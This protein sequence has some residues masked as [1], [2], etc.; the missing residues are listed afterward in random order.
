MNK[1]ADSKGVY[2]QSSDIRSRTYL[3]YRSDMKR[4]AIV[5]LEIMDWFER[6]LRELHKTDNV[7]VEKSGGDAHMW[8]TRSGKISGEPDYVACINNEEHR[9]EFQYAN[10]GNLPSYD[11]KVSKVGKKVRGKRVPHSDRKFLYILMPSNQFAVFS[12]EWVMQNGKEEG[13]PAWGNR[14]AF[15]VPRDKFSEIFRSGRALAGEIEVTNKKIKLLETQSE[16]IENESKRLSGELQCVVDHERTFRIVPKTL[17]GFY[18]ACF[19]MD[20][21]SRRPENHSLWLVYGSSFYSDEL[22]SRELA[23]LIYSLDFLYG[24]SESL[25]KNVLDS[26]VSVMQ[27]ITARIT[28]TQKRGL[29]TCADLS[30]KEEIVNFLFTVNLY[31]DI[32][33]ELRCLYEVDCF[34]PVRKIFQSVENPDSIFRQISDSGSPATVAE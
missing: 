11:F 21:I 15:R 6:K 23:L 31:E 32:V 27:R 16:F 12:P 20:Q 1:I 7:T 17:D 19:L 8:F 9:F 30:P 13:V 4:K 25:E 5:E 28:S 14:T 3:Q 33:Q 34:P 10:D 18:K 22:N 29:K 26:F 24:G 2:A